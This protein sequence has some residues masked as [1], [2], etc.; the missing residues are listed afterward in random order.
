MKS[1]T[2]VRLFAM[3][4][5]PLAFP[6]VAQAHSGSSLVYDC[7][8]GIGHP[9]HG[10][11]HLAAMLAVGVWAAQLGG[12]ARWVVPAAFVTV[13]TCAAVIGSRGFV[14]PGVEPMIA[15]SVLALGVLIAAAARMPLAS[16][17][18]L[19]SFFAAAHGF[20]HGTEMPANAG[21][22]SYTAGFVLATAALHLLG[23]AIG[24][25][26]LGRSLH[27]PRALGAVCAAAGAAL[28]FV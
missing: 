9:F 23:L 27:L 19:V 18:T 17:V 4:A 28:L 20:A 14:V 11:D 2:P 13:M 26:A 6:A 21:A 1:I 15:T 10:W 24:H 5:T 8:S 25:L 22:F 12:R 16:S 7:A 3:L